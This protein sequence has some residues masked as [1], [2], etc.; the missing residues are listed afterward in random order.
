M[1]D[2][3]WTTDNYLAAEV[4]DRLAWVYWGHQNK[5]LPRTKQT[6]KP[7]PLPRPADERKR[8]ELAEANLAKARAFRAATT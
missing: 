1:G 8:R 3:A 5:G 6:E 4:A 7:T 2:D